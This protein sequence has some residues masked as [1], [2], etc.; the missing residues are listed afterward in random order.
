MQN[1]SDP[2]MIKIKLHYLLVK[3]EGVITAVVALCALAAIFSGIAW[4]VV[5]KNSLLMSLVGFSSC[6][7]VG[8][9]FWRFRD[10]ELSLRH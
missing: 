6:Y 9:N 3:W 10:R 5:R 2:S 4:L 7:L 8:K 1:A